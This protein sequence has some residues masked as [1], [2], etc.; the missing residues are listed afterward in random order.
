MRFAMRQKRARRGHAS[1]AAHRLNTRMLL[2][3]H[4]SRLGLF[5]LKKT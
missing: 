1:M 3:I 2:G 4:Q 5:A